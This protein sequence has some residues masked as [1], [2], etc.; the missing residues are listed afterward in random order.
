MVGRIVTYVPFWSSFLIFSQDTHNLGISSQ[1]NSQPRLVLGVPT[2][3]H[4]TDFDGSAEESEVEILQIV[5]C[6]FAEDLRDFQFPSLE[7]EKWKPKAEEDQVVDALLDEF[8]LGSGL[9]QIWFV[10]TLWPWFHFCSRNLIIS[11]LP[12]FTLVRF[13]LFPKAARNAIFSTICSAICSAICP[14]ICP[15]STPL[16]YIL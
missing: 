14:T 8:D 2:V 5:N 9:T 16:I 15:I 13:C 12:G 7:T 4:S 3:R 11:D 6:P 10:H 1:A